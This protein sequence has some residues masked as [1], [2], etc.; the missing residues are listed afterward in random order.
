MGQPGMGQPGMGQPGM[1]QPGMGMAPPGMG[2]PMGY[3]GQGQGHGQGMM[4]GMGQPGMGQPGMGQ[5]GMGTQSGGGPPKTMMLQ[6][7]EGIV[8]VAARGAGQIP[9]SH[10]VAPPQQMPISSLVP[11][12]PAG[13]TGAFWAISLILG[14]AAGALA[15]AVV[16]AL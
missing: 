10:A 15:Y 8:S 5:P 14:A 16:R 3:P 11:D 4:P 1:G 7:T 13:A 9:A 2:P 6:N 12:P